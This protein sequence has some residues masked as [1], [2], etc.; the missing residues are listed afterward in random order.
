MQ[1]DVGTLCR[2]RLERARED[3]LTAKRNQKSP[4]T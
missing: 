2:Y 1:L 4:L 3:L